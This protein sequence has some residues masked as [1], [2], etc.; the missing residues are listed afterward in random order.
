MCSVLSAFDV[1]ETHR[2]RHRLRW[3]DLSHTPIYGAKDTPRRGN[4]MI[5]R[6]VLFSAASLL[7]TACSLTLPVQGVVQGSRETFTGTATGGVDGSGTLTITSNTGVTCKG[8][9]V[10]LSDREGRGTFTCSDGSTGP[11]D[12]VST[13]THGTGQGDLGGRKFTFTFG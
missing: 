13:G 1:S 7:L 2:S 12:F 11:F 4:I 10:Y 5:S 6:L 3:L 8:N 9:F